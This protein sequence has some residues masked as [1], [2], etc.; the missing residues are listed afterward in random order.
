MVTNV[1]GALHIT[2]ILKPLALGIQGKLANVTYRTSSKTGPI[3][4][5]DA[6]R[7][8]EN[9]PPI[10]VLEMLQEKLILLLSLSLYPRHLQVFSD[11]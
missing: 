10:L 1:E 7:E 8:T 2:L 11:I 3:A 5:C 9:L 6:C 4:S